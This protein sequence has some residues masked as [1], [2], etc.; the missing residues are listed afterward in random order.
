MK[1]T[2]RWSALLFST[3]ILLALHLAGTPAQAQSSYFTSRGC[4][5]CHST[6]VVATCAGCHEHSGTLTATK[7]KTTSYSPGE[8][9][10]ITLTASGARSGWIGVRLYNQSGAEIA[11]STGSQSG[12]G[13]STVYPA[14]LSAPAP[15]TAGTYTWRI[16][17]LGN[18]NGTGAGD[19]HSE[20]SV[21]VSISV[22][23][24]ADTTIPVVSAFTLPA[25]STSLTIPVS[26]FTA[27]DNVG[28]SGYRITTSTTAPLASATGWSATKPTSVTAAA[29]GSVT[30]YAWARDAAGNVSLSKSASVVITLPDTTLPVVS[31]F[32][33]PATSS[34][35][36]IPVSTFTATDNIG[37]TG[38]RITTSAT[39]PL[40]SA[41]AWSTAKP[42]SVTAAAAGSVTFYA[43]AKDAAG[44]V[45]L[46]KSA[47]VVITL[48]A[49]ID[50][51]NP[52]L[53][54]ST[55]AN[56]AFTNNATLNVSGSAS[57]AGGLQSVIVNGQPVT[58]NADGTFSVALTL[59]SGSNSIEVIATDKADN[60]TVFS[61]TINYDPNAPILAVTAPTDNSMTT[62]SFIT[63]SGTV[64][65][66]STVTLKTNNSALQYAT[67]SGNAFS[68]VVYLVPGLNTIDI[69]AVDPAGNISSAKRTVTYESNKPTLAVTYP[70]QD[71]TT[72]ADYLILRGTVADA[73]GR[74]TVR[75]LMDGRIYKPR[76]VRGTFAQKLTF[77]ANKQYA[78][79]VTAWDAAGNKT[80]VVRNV[81]HVDE[82]HDDE[83]DDD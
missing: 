80:S 20:K 35:L 63:I 67:L 43:W 6:P 50:T 18:N 49:A 1:M 41:T 65:E 10:T 81:I 46:S 3:I 8:T 33:L 5:D 44:N 78:I 75:V 24:A 40:A 19:V 66:V 57:D 71:I 51:V 45:S 34:S 15:A 79:T 23:A 37:V 59:Q 58:I 27:T 52:Q 68:A 16:A 36:T 22:A 7:N 39:A 21:N 2:T 17:Y 69:T 14:V 54:V 47:V 12:M 25:T 74:V 31:A 56:D 26:T 64:S 28:V 32:T 82:E 29:A 61:R 9:V 38:Y 42:T 73:Q 62:E 77:R 30:F 60:Q 53:T 55:L 48:P 76:V 72:A 83:H 13:G 11:R 4:V 70:N